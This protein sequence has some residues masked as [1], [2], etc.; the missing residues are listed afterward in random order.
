MPDPSYW[1]LV[2]TSAFLPLGYGIVFKSAPTL[3][4]AVVWMLVGM[5]GWIIE[6][7]AVGDDD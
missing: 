7:V 4:L 1:P 2:M 5:Y 6:P 3:A